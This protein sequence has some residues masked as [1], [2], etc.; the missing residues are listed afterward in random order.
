[1]DNAFWGSKSDLLI[2][3]VDTL[4]GGRTFARLQEQGVEPCDLGSRRGQTEFLV[5]NFSI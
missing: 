2:A 5:S 1:M 4:C 3:S